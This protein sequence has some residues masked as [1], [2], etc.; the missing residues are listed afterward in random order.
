MVNTS[1]QAVQTLKLSSSSSSVP[2]QGNRQKVGFR[3]D[4]EIEVLP[5]ELSITLREESLQMTH[6]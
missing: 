1:M 3:A 5:P 4:K 6:S 2:Q